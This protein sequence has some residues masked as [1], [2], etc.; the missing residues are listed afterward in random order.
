MKKILLI[1][2]CFTQSV[3]ADG[4]QINNNIEGDE[5]N[6][7]SDSPSHMPTGWQ[8]FFWYAVERDKRIELTGS[9]IQT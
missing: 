4:V 8:F 9:Q 6:T 2:I 3:M 7:A 5:I 1:I